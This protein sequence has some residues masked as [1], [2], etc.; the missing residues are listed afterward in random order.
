MLMG[1]VDLFRLIGH[2]RGV[3]FH[4]HTSYTTIIAYYILVIC[5]IDP[6]VITSGFLLL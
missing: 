2:V 4:I 5:L 3:Y 6:L 1:L